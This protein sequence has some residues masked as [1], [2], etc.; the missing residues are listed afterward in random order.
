MRWLV[1]MLLLVGGTAFADDL[2]AAKDHFQRGVTMY[3][4]QRYVDAAHEYEAAYEAHPDA[5]LLFN[6]AQAYRL[7]GQ[8]EKALFAYRAFVRDAPTVAQRPIAEKYI[9]ELQKEVDARKAR[10]Q[11]EEAQKATRTTVVQPPA[12]RG[13]ARTEQPGADRKPT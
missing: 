7:A 4:L 5:A 1:C 10:Q 9:A 6:I 12:D 8:P 13:L 3:N 11:E 2:Q